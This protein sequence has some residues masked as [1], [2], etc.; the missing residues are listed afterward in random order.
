M[1]P[2]I[3]AVAVLLAA[4]ALLGTIAPACAQVVFP[5]QNPS[6]R[7]AGM[8]G[9]SAAVVWSG[10]LNTWANP[11]LLGYASG[12]TLRWSRADLSYSAP[13]VRFRAGGIEYGWGGL[14]VSFREDGIRLDVTLTESFG[15]PLPSNEV[16]QRVRRWGGAISVSHVLETVLGDASLPGIVRHADL[17]LGFA[18]KRGDFR[19]PYGPGGTGETSG[20]TDLGL[21]AR[22]TPLPETPGRRLFLD[23]TYGYSVLEEPFYRS[24]DGIT[25]EHRRHGIGVRIGRPLAAGDPAGRGRRLINWLARG[26]HPSL[27]LTVAA[28]FDRFENP[29]F[30][31]GWQSRTSRDIGAELELVNA[32]A[33][34]FGHIRDEVQDLDSS[35]FGAGIGVPI[36]GVMRLRY[37][38][39]RFP[40]GGFGGLDLGEL[41]NR[42]AV[43]V[44]IDPVAM[45]RQ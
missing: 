2:P 7:S 14:G 11:A 8:G 10:D 30:F 37:D 18:R 16:S 28:D 21:L 33:V 38:Y 42:H 20:A 31:G 6:V 32:L 44:W 12:L 25:P 39:A 41:G 36:A 22:V 1:R 3:I 5:M 23:L 29:G 17:A 15:N 26:A 45:L 27:A 19:Y 35:C 43:S 40:N 34:R 9:P 24:T 13:P 4:G